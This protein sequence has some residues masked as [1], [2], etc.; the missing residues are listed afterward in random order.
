ML[1]PSGQLPDIPA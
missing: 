1:R